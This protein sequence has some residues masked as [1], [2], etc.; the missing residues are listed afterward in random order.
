MDIFIV[1]SIIIE[2]VSEGIS[3]TGEDRAV[4]TAD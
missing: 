2:F 1:F 3:F 4:R